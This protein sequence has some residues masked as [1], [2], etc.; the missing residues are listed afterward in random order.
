MAAMDVIVQPSSSPEPFGRAIAE[1]QAIGVP[2]IGSAMGGIPELIEDGSTGMLFPAGNSKSLG[3]QV[4]RI[5][6]DP[7]LASRLR[8]GGR[9][10]AG[11]RFTRQRYV[12]AIESIYED[13]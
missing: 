8:S 13:L 12:Q 4:V 7:A 10:R 9:K 2:V 5:L 11:E 6:G 1:A 3:D